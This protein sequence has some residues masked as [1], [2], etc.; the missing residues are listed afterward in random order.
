MAAVTSGA[1]ASFFAHSIKPQQLGSRTNQSRGLSGFSG[2]GSGGKGGDTGK[3]SSPPPS[4]RTGSK[5]DMPAR[6]SN[7][8]TIS[9]TPVLK[10]PIVPIPRTWDSLKDPLKSDP[11]PVEDS[12]ANIE[13]NL[14]KL[15][16]ISSVTKKKQAY[17]PYLLISQL[18][19]TVMPD[20]IRRL[21]DSKDS[22]KDIIYHRNQFMEFQNKVTVVFRSATDAVDFITQKYGK[23]MSGHKL[24]MTMLDPYNPRDKRSIPPNLR[25]EPFSGHLVLIS[26]IPAASRPDHLRTEFR[27]FQLMD[28][29]EAAIIP[30]PSKRMASSCQYLIRLSSRSEAFRF[31]RT[32]HN[33]FFQFKE[34]RKRCPIRTTIIY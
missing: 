16:A 1:V 15:K 11:V 22:I 4:F 28:T 14:K 26:G 20:D 18:P 3:V 13:L 8:T 27:R 29:T 19:S 24:N 31:V 25:S 17:S 23:F 21:A 33:T 32:Y 10:R 34:F 9:P 30:V 2:F 5:W 6:P 12:Q 7:T